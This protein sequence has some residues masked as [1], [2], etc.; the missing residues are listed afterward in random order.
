MQTFLLKL[1][2]IVLC[3]VKGIPQRNGSLYK[4]QKGAIKMS[5]QANY[6]SEPDIYIEAEYTNLVTPQPRKKGL[7]LRPCSVSVKM[8]DG[9]W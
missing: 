8:G 3:I 7:C 9:Q 2:Q 4:Y 5:Y 6:P 1:S